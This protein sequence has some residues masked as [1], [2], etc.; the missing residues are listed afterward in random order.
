MDESNRRK[1]EFK[2][3]LI[4]L[5]EKMSAKDEENIRFL[6]EED[7]NQDVSKP[8]DLFREL[9]QKDKISHE[10][11]G[12]LS[13][14]YRN[15]GRIDLA[16]EVEQCRQQE[17]V[18]M[19]IGEEQ[20]LRHLEGEVGCVLDSA[21]QTSTV[22]YVISLGVCAGYRQRGVA[23]F[24]M[25]S[26]M[27][28]VSRIPTCDV[29]YLHV[30]S[31]NL[32]AINMV[33]VSRYGG[34]VKIWWWCQDVVVVSRCGGGVKIW[35]WCQD[36]VVVSRCGG[37]VKIWWWC[38]DVVVVLRYGGGVKIWWCQDMVV[39][40]YGG[41]VKMWWWYQEQDDI[42]SQ[43]NKAKARARYKADPEKKKA[44]VRDS[45][46]ADPEK[47]KAS[48]RDS[49]KADPEK[50][51]ASVRDSYKAD[52]EKKKASVRDSY[53]AYPEKKK[54]SVRDS[55]KADPEK[56]KASVR[57][58]YKAD[59]EK[60]K[61]SV[62]EATTQILNLSN[63][64]K[65]SDI[66]RTSR[67]TALLK[68]RNTRTI[69]LPLRHL[70]G[71]GI[72]MT[73]LSDW[74]NVLPRGSGIAGVTELPLPPKATHPPNSA[75]CLLR[76]KKMEYARFFEEDLKDE[77]HPPTPLPFTQPCT[78]PATAARSSAPSA[79]SSSSSTV[80]TASSSRAAVTSSSSRA[81]PAATSTSP[82]H[83]HQYQCPHHHF[84]CCPPGRCHHHPHGSHGHN[85]A[86]VRIEEGGN[87]EVEDKAEQFI[88]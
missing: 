24:L 83:R 5:G 64:L 26:L 86:A 67:R 43:E 8:T 61:A 75:L 28:H 23:S 16:I 9:L 33:M 56:K 48:V 36:V 85:E 10:T 53:K 15:I 88:T 12:A 77:V 62:R 34:G 40:R 13:A 29:I 63:L 55:Y 76:K 30:L 46:K 54:A 66:K 38:Q 79:T 60:K 44:S 4:R 81:A 70:K 52:P 71:I 27:H 68:G 58:S 20:S 41:G 42:L 18:G 6:Y 57:D 82:H 72:G 45:Y 49:Y 7:M 1:L 14:I 35:W 65:G 3:L 37:G 78:A 87:E 25:Q 73:P 74:L 2:K 51:K 21:H 84:A 31:T 17:L 19:V 39:S 59:P 80:P 22:M 50:K 11:P 69:Q 47:K 32:S